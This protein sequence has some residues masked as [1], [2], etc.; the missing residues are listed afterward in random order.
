MRH[1]RFSTFAL[2]PNNED[3]LIDA[4]YDVSSPLFTI[5]PPVSTTAG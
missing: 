5:P 1:N 4:L 3:V 2:K